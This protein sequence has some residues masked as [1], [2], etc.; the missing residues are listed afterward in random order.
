M[1]IR[2]DTDDNL[3]AEWQGVEIPNE[4]QAP[5]HE[6]AALLV[7]DGKLVAGLSTEPG[8][9]VSHL[10]LSAKLQESEL[11]ELLG[12]RIASVYRREMLAVAGFSDPAIGGF[13]GGSAAH[14]WDEIREDFA[15]MSKHVLF[16]KGDAAIE[17]AVRRLGA[18]QLDGFMRLLLIL[19]AL[20]LDGR[21]DERTIRGLLSYHVANADY[22]VWRTIAMELL[23]PLTLA[24][25]ADIRME[26]R[27]LLHELQPLADDAIRQELIQLAN[28]PELYKELN[29]HNLLRG[30]APRGRGKYAWS[31]LLDG[32]N[33]PWLDWIQLVR[34]RMAHMECYSTYPESRCLMWPHMK[35]L[36]KELRQIYGTRNWRVLCLCPSDAEL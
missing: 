22:P 11:Q 21:L 7:R 30:M 9:F 6:R 4:I 32:L 25:T 5:E 20:R 15:S 10:E 28:L 18:D 24:Q 14:Y 1:A 23:E 16:E 36:R 29:T 2:N 8:L 12:E 33:L 35:Q 27:R 17:H 19:S 26:R 31:Y 3:V 13:P 34:Y